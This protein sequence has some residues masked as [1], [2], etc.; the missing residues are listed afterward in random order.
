MTAELVND[1]RVER[2]DVPADDPRIVSLGLEDPKTVEALFRN[3]DRIKPLLKGEAAASDQMGR[4]TPLAGGAL[5]AAGLFRMAVPASRGGLDASLPDQLEAVTQVA[6]IDGGIGWTVAILNASGWYASFLDDESYADLYPSI[7]V[8]TSFSGFPPAKAVEV[9]DDKYLIEEGRWNWGSGGYHAER[10]LGGA[11]VYDR[12]GNP[13]LDEN[14]EQKYLGIWLPADKVRQADNWNPL[15][16]RASGSSSYYLTEPITVPRRWSINYMDDSRP[17]QFP[18]MGVM[19]G[20]AQHLVDLTVEQLRTRKKF[21]A[22]VGPRDREVLAETMASV[23]MLVFGLRG[24]AEYLEKV[25]RER[26]SGRLTED[27]ILWVNSIGMPTRTLLAHVRDVTQ[28]IFGSGLVN[29]GSEFGRI[30][31]DIFVAFSHVQMR[32]SDS[33]EPK[34][35]RVDR[36][37]DDPSAIVAAYDESWPLDVAR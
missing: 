33:S 8:P 7:D 36:L 32:V 31:R 9:D 34:G 27:E 21:G 25:R 22:P 15:G 4:T 28:D 2:G 30:L 5:R 29:D 11:K 13:V 16:V 35:S 19:A 6:R 37:L 26:L 24:V 12:D 23:D 3:L 17:Y 10:W 1:V 14:G 18:L 20:M